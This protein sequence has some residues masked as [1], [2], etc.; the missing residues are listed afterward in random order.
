MHHLDED[1]QRKHPEIPWRAVYGLRNRIV[2]DYD[3]VNVELIWQIISE[4]LDDL[5]AQ[6]R[7]LK[8]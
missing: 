5:L 2:H 7:A 4:D 3:G 8:D 1:Y 6:L